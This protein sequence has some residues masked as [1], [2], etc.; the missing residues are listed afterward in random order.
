[1]KCEANPSSSDQIW[2]VQPFSSL[3][4]LA[5]GCPSFSAKAEAPGG[6]GRNN[7][8]RVRDAAQHRTVMV[9]AQNQPDLG[10]AR[11]D[12]GQPL[13][14]SQAD[15]IQQP[16]MGVKRRMVERDDRGL[17]RRDGEHVPQ[18]SARVLA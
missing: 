13:S 5:N 14:M 11:H 6:G 7:R 16:V 8:G 17:A 1:M 18:A 4:R 3:L 9:P 15:G 2:S 12:L 10:V